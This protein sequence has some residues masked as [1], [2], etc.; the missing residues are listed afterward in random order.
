MQAAFS[1]AGFEMR[2]RD[3]L[4]SEAPLEAGSILQASLKPLCPTMAS[5]QACLRKFPDIKSGGKTAGCQVLNM[6]TVLL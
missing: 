4:E 5:Y 3:L 6:V 2:H 1:A